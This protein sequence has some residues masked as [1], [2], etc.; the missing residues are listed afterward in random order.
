MAEQKKN[1]ILSDVAN[2]HGEQFE[3]PFF[4]GALVE[5]RSDSAWRISEPGRDY[6]GSLKLTAILLR[7]R[8]L[9]T[10]Q[11]HIRR[12]SRLDGRTIFTD[13]E[14]AALGDSMLFARLRECSDEEGGGGAPGQAPPPF[15]WP[16]DERDGQPGERARGRR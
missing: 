16:G 7:L 5:A 3:H 10:Q 9:W 1:N 13:A 8:M 4:H 2:D 6:I 14:W 11:G 15:T 12:V